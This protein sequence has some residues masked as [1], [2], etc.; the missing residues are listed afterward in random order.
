LPPKEEA[1]GT[2]RA[3]GGARRSLAVNLTS[4]YFILAGGQLQECCFRLNRLDKD[5]E[6]EGGSAVLWTLLV[7]LLVLWMLGWGLHI[8]G[9]LIHLLLLAALVVL[10]ANLLIG[11]RAT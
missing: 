5:R 11:R 3:G 9:A 6:P 10:L 4:E 2:S 8:A 7:I 1:A